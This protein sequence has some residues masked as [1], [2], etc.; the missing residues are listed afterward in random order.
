VFSLKSLLNFWSLLIIKWSFLS[1]AGKNLLM[2]RHLPDLEECELIL[3]FS[4]QFDGNMLE[5][6]SIAANFL[7]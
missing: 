3:S 7:G 2:L 6:L 5:L 1:A 4:E